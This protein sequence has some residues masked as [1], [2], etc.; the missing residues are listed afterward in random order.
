MK[1]GRRNGFI[2]I[3]INDYTEKEY[4]FELFDKESLRRAFI[5]GFQKGLNCLGE[6]NYYGSL[7]N[8]FEE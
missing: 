8:G 5:E 6:T 2:H 3:K 7:E 4:H 1:E